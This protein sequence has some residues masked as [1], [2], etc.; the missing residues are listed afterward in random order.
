MEG[1]CRQNEI[2]K[3]NTIFIMDVFIYGKINL[4]YIICMVINHNDLDIEFVSFF[5]GNIPW[6]ISREM[7]ISQLIISPEKQAC[8]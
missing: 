8:M 5:E 7:Y 2:W 4:S 6:R 3:L 1:L